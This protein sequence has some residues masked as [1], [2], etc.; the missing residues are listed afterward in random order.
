MRNKFN[1]LKLFIIIGITGILSVFLYFYNLELRRNKDASVFLTKCELKLSD[2]QYETF[3]DYP[4]LSGMQ[5][6]EK[7][8]RL[9]ELIK[10]DVMKILEHDNP[11][12][13]WC[14][15][16]ILNYKIMYRDNRI[17]SIL[18]EG[19]YGAILPGRGQPDTAMVTTV[20]MEEEKIL[21]LEDVVADYN[22]LYDMLMAD[23]FENTTKWEG[24]A[25]QYKISEEYSNSERL[26][27]ELKGDDEDIEW[28]ID[29]EHF[30][31]VIFSGRT[32]YNEYAIGLQDAKVFL[33][34]IF[35]KKIS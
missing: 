6:K 16:A 29:D 21:S 2:E 11:D 30:V 8:K 20:D 25:G 7:E 31:I 12:D 35:Y 5:D 27:G 17:I 18:Y 13:E 34:K 1:A 14:F 19:S 9:N 26:M 10:K 22:E 23:K 33:K 24:Q 28:Y 32:D 15:S 3:I 4:Q